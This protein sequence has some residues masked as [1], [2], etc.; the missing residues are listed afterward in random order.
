MFFGRLFLFNYVEK[1]IN[2]KSL[3]KDQHSF[4]QL[5]LITKADFVFHHPARSPFSDRNLGFDTSLWW[6]IFCCLTRL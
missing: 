4:E 1:Q 3:R 6:K 2:N 5:I